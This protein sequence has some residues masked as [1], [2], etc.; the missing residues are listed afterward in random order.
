MSISERDRKILMLLVPIALVL[1]YWFVVLAPKRQEASKVKSELSQAQSQRDTAQQ[2]AAQL[3]SA[4]RN[5]AAD[6]ATVIELGKSIPSDVD[7]PSLMVQLDS[8]ARG[9][10]ISFVDIKTGQRDSSTS[11]ASSS[12]S[13]PNGGTGPNAP[14]APPAQSGP[15]QAAQSAGS[16]VNTANSASAAS[17][18]T[19]ATAGGSGSASGAAGSPT[20]LDT[21]PLDF[22]FHGSFTRLADFF[23]RMKRFVQVA[24]KQIVVKGRLIKINSFSFSSG[25]TFPEI[26][27]KVHATVYLAPKSQGVAG[28]AGPQGPAGSG[29]ASQGSTGSS[30]TPAATVTP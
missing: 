30:S 2:A 24:N 25:D 21:V 5:Y 27:A 19:S 26:D 28:G 4:K 3:S 15:G 22:E 7:M 29:S 11:S 16:A 12:S 10:G 6:Y 20:G 14:G 18:G 13:A 1:V 9:T 23:H 8:A 17:A